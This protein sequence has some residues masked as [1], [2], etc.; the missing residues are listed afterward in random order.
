M[1]STITILIVVLLA[2]S[3]VFAAPLG[4]AART[5]IPSEIQ[6]LI[7]VDYRTMTSSPTALALRDKVLP[8]NLKEFETALKGV[9]LDP[10]RDVDQ[11]TF[12][13]FRSGKSGL[14]I[15]GIA[16]GNFA[17]K[18]FLKKMAVRKQKPLKYRLNQIWPMSGGMQM[19]FLDPSTLLFGE[20]AAVKAALDARDGEAQSMEYNQSMLNMISSVEDGPVWSVLDQPGTQNMMLSALGDASKL[21]DYDMVKKRLLGSSYTMDFQ[22]GVN[23]DLNVITSDSFTA[24][25]L[26]SLVK[27]GVMYK[28]ATGT[29]VEKV[30]LDGVSVDSD[31]SRLRIHFKTDDKKFQSLLNTDLFAA[32]SH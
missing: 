29:A 14:K 32:V 3:S 28:K 25:T 31:S 2:S 20:N 30:A 24:A 19:T 16:Q 18:T 17:I 27:A 11:L 12:A 21:A 23:F 26:S 15:V 7:S 6:Q 1:K 8:D 5:A 9:G 13:S 4:T 10:G 22:N